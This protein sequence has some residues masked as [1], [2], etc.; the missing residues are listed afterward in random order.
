MLVYLLA[1]QEVWVRF[2]LS[3]PLG[4]WCNQVAYLSP[5]QTVWVQIPLP[6]LPGLGVIAA[7]KSVE[8]LVWMQLP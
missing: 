7:Q 3:A 2:P 5:E 1:K 4:I 8:L 6:P